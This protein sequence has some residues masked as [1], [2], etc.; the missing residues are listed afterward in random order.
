METEKAKHDHVLGLLTEGNNALIEAEELSLSVKILR[1]ELEEAENQLDAQDFHAAVATAEEATSTARELIHKFVTARDRLVEIQ[2]FIYDGNGIGTDTGKATDLLGEAR[3]AMAEQRLDEA[4]DLTDRAENEVN[5][6]QEEMA[7]YELETV[8]DLREEAEEEGMIL[9][10]I[11]TTIEEANELSEAKDHKATILRLREGIEEGRSLLVKYQVAQESIAQA[12]SL[13][14]IMNELGIDSGVPTAELDKSKT[15]IPKEEY[16]TAKEL[17]DGIIGN[18]ERALEDHLTEKVEALRGSFTR[19]EEIGI[20]V[21]DIE[22]SF[23]EA[24]PQVDPIEY[25][26]MASVIDEH[27]AQ[28][29]ERTSAY[30]DALTRIEEAQTLFTDAEDL[31]VDISTA[32]PTLEGARESLAGGIYADA[33][34]GADQAREEILELQRQFVNKYIHD[35]VDLITELQNLGVDTV[36]SNEF[37]DQARAGLDLEEYPS[38]HSAA[39][40]AI[41]ESQRVKDL[42]KEASNLI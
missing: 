18:S 24:H 19:A 20:Q 28:V 26:A 39:L 1:V 7:S 12:D 4:L 31:Q 33:A 14:T 15:L 30:D 37:L 17:A 32:L 35:A 3:D 16:G 21:G 36:Q 22:R 2:A 13:L 29:K 11:D 5:E 23:N 34:K 40:Q 8:L 10:S 27:D 41:T 25:L 6:R 42:F 9:T 38:A